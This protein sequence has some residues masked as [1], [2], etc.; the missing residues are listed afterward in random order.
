MCPHRCKRRVCNLVY[1]AYSQTGQ[2][3][4]CKVL[5]KKFL[6]GREHMV[7]FLL[8]V[9]GKA[10]Y[11]VRNEIAVLKRVSAGHQ[12]IVQLHDFFE[13]THNLYVRSMLGDGADM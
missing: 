5:N 13:T 12:N 10:D 11:Q 6:V 4:A 3:Y 9:R 1:L 2:Y 8:R 7:S